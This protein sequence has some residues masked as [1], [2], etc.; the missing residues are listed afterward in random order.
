[1]IKQAF[2]PKLD[3]LLFFDYKQV[4][5]RLLAYYLASNLGDTSMADVFKRGEDLHTTTAASVLGKSIGDVTEEERQIGKTWNFLTIYGGGPAKAAS[6]LGISLKTAKE[7]QATFHKRWPSIK[8]LHNPP[9]RNGGYSDGEGPGL[10]Q[11]VMAARRTPDDPNGYLT[12]L[13]G[14]QLRP[15]DKAGNPAP[16]KTLNWVIQGCAGDLIRQALVKVH[17]E[18][19]TGSLTSHLVSNVH[20]E[21]FIDAIYDEI[22]FLEDR[23]PI[24][25][26]HRPISE[27]VPIEVDMEWTTESWANKTTYKE[28]LIA[29]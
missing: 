14:R 6:S 26:D 9:F 15:V 2:H 13:W 18:L 3:A 27:V 12:T 1:M 10:M 23:V 24:L 5:Y 19:T 28:D 16:H 7:Q 17:K 29:R 4:E 25:M 21:L 8:L 20:D 11:R 22:P